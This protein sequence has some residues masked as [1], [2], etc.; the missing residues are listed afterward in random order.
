MYALQTF[1]PNFRQLLSTH[2]LSGA[3]VQN[4]HILCYFYRIFHLQHLFAA[5]SLISKTLLR[6]MNVKVSRY[7]HGI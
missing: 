7:Q 6:V 2:V 1:K 4:A 5:S 3:A